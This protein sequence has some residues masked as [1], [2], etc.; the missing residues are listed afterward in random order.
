MYICYP[1]D[2]PL[3]EIDQCE[4]IEFERD[5]RDERGK[6]SP[7]DFL[8]LRAPVS[9]NLS[10]VL[11]NMRIF[12]RLSQLLRTSITSWL[13]FIVISEIA[14]AGPPFKTDDPEPVE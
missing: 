11:H 8:H 9:Q 5:V 4:T 7:A 2:Q 13:V 12:K 6:R 10:M 1:K 14:M 3:N